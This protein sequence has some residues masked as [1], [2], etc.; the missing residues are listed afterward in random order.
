[1]VLAGTWR[2]KAVHFKYPLHLQ[3][4]GKLAPFRAYAAIIF[5]ILRRFNAVQTSFHST[6]ALTN[7]RMLIRFEFAEFILKRDF[8]FGG[9][10]SPGGLSSSALRPRAASA[11]LNQTTFFGQIHH[12]YKPL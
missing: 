10:P 4:Q 11:G 6:C 8:F 12:L 3:N 1:V 9:S 7:P 2:R 5:A